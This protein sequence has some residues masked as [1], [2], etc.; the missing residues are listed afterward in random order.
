MLSRATVL[1][2]CALALSACFLASEEEPGDSGV[3]IE[4]V[5][6][7]LTV[8]PGKTAQLKGYVRGS[9]GWQSATCKVT[10]GT[11]KIQNGDT[12]ELLM[13]YTA[14]GATGSA[15]LTFSHD[16]G[17]GKPG[18]P[19]KALAATAAITIDGKPAPPA[20]IPV[21]WQQS[22]HGGSIVDIGFSLDGS[23]IASAAKD[24]TVKLHDWATGKNTGSFP[25]KYPTAV[26]FTPNSSAVLVGRGDGLVRIKAKDGKETGDVVLDLPPPAV[27][28][29]WPLLPRDIACDAVSGKC[30]A[31]RGPASLKNCTGNA[32]ICLGCTS[33]L[34]VFDAPDGNELA[35]R[36]IALS[37]VDA[38]AWMHVAWSPDGKQLAVLQ[39]GEGVMG[40]IL[41]FDAATGKP[42]LTI[43]V[44]TGFDVYALAWSADGS[45]QTNGASYSGTT[46]E[47][48][49][50]TGINVSGTGGVWHGGQRTALPTT[51]NGGPLALFEKGMAT[52][53]TSGPSGLFTDAVAAR[54]ADYLALLAENLNVSNVDNQLFVYSKST[55]QKLAQLQRSTV[56]ASFD[57]CPTGELL[58]I[59]DDKT[60]KIAMPGGYSPSPFT[61]AGETLSSP[62]FVIYDPIL[63]SPLPGCH[64]LL[65]SGKDESVI[66]SVNARAVV[67]R[68][69]FS[70]AKV[71]STLTRYLQP[72]TV[73]GAKARIVD[74]KGQVRIEMP[75]AV[76][77]WCVGNDSLCGLDAKGVYH[78][79]FWG[80]GAHTQIQL[81]TGSIG[82][83]GLPRRVRGDLFFVQ[84]GSLVFRKPYEGAKN[85]E[86][87][88]THGNAV[89][90]TVIDDGGTD[91]IIVAGNAFVLS[92]PAQAIRDRI[93]E[94]V[95]P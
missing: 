95:T 65:A 80:D 84:P 7:A 20:L 74:D 34:F 8:R 27:L 3:S 17:G 76:K 25:V 37:P 92:H 29:T 4:L 13:T 60:M 23:Q 45:L 1:V 22:S 31:V 49:P 82:E 58:Y 79:W 90:A 59:A 68:V 62:I 87:A 66:V 69:P 91:R 19:V 67:K 12:Q 73:F 55:G 5:P 18:A 83:I 57:M 15:T 54:D 86:I 6:A 53:K 63:D 56:D 21:D 64:V 33:G 75:E 47:V 35:A 14:P 70:A 42:A 36:R 16:G 81:T 71:N 48:L 50:G 94:I 10:L 9:T 51:F 77:R 41:T 32:C 2:F 52:R 89:P 11:C 93:L 43:Q 78:T 61:V 28:N 46:G 88:L 72:N 26:A 39:S 24:D 85:I 38:P 40:T 44:A 30:A